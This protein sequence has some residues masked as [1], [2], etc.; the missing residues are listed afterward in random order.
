MTFKSAMENIAYQNSQY[1]FSMEL[2]RSWE[3]KYEIKN[4]GVEYGTSID[5]I[6]MASKEFLFSV[7]IWSKEKWNTDGQVLKE[8]IGDHT[9]L[10]MRR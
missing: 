10:S 6:D 4:N 8:I 7:N 2:P 5:F 9:I 1:H 3:G